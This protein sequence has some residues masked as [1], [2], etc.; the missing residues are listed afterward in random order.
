[1][2]SGRSPT[3]VAR[4]RRPELGDAGEV[5]GAEDQR[6]EEHARIA[7]NLGFAGPAGH[8]AGNVGGQLASLR[9][10]EAVSVGIPDAGSGR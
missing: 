10:R 6:H 1:M 9:C 8:R 7:E 5:R 2:S 4:R 3:A